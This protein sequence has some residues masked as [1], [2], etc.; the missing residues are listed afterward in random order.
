[1]APNASEFVPDARL[2]W[3]SAVASDAEAVE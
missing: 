3:P 1:L 2:F